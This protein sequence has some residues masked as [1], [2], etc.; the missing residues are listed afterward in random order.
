MCSWNILV[1]VPRIELGPH[2]PK[3]RI[4]PLYDTPNI[5]KSVL[6]ISI[7]IILS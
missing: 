4:L 1:G 2:A 6:F 5:E 7:L 3:A